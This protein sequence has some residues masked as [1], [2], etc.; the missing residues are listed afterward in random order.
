MENQRPKSRHFL[1]WW[2][3]STIN[4]LAVAAIQGLVWRQTLV[5]H[6]RH[7]RWKWR[8]SVVPRWFFSVWL[9]RAYA[10]AKFP[11]PR[12]SQTVTTSETIPNHHASSPASTV[13]SMRNDDK[14]CTG[15]PRNYISQVHVVHQVILPASTI[16]SCIFCWTYCCMSLK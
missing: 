12:S 15:G 3:W 4:K 14:V 13:P 10:R 1:S 8:M 6:W 11:C 2:R 16:Y 9:T 7:I 5:N